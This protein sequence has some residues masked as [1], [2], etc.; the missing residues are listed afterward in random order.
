M[1][2][3]RVGAAALAAV[4]AWRDGSEGTAKVA[5]MLLR[6]V[7]RGVMRLSIED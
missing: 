1:K 5:A 6:K 7:R 4:A 3:I 2:A